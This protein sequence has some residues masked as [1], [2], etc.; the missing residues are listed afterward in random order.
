MIEN[1]Y[2]LLNC[3]RT[4]LQLVGGGKMRSFRIVLLVVVLALSLLVSGMA[5]AQR[6]SGSGGHGGGGH[7]GDYHGGG[8]HHGYY[9]GSG[10]DVVIGGPF[11]G[12]PW[13]YPPYY[14]P[15]YYPY[16]YTPIVEVPS[17]PPTYIER[18]QP[19][20]TPPGVWY[21]CPDSK[22]YYPYVKEC[23]GGWQTV[24]A[25]PPSEQGR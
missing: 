18:S 20:S 12:V 25:E 6:Y 16:D 10:I 14:Y 19:S 5:F 22:T 17:S 11:W 13:Y 3:K 23:P 15:Y 8:G 7:R 4:I 24:P 21:Y 9:Y 1:L 2:R